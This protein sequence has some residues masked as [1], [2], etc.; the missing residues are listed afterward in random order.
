MA[1]QK[2]SKSQNWG[3]V[4][5]PKESVPPRPPGHVYIFVGGCLCGWVCVSVFVSVCVS[6]CLCVC[7]CV[8]V[9]CDSLTAVGYD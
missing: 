3:A 8:C 1:N 5:K 2:Q 4:P 7:V 9:G 6:V